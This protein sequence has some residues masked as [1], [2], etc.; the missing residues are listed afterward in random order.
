MNRKAKV[1]LKLAAKLLA[2]L[3]I[4]VLLYQ[5]SPNRWPECQGT[6]VPRHCVEG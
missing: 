2:A 3:A 5:T 4:L 6:K 1:S